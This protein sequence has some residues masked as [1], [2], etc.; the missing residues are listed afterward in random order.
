MKWISV[1]DRLPGIDSTVMVYDAGY[2]GVFP[3]RYDEFG[4]FLLRDGAGEDEAYE[5]TH[6]MPL[7]KP[8]KEEAC[9]KTK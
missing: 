8:P 5:V 3:A 4:V 7:P 2:E 6:W 1:K 9:R